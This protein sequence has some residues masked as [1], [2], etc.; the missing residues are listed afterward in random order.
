MFLLNKWDEFWAIILTENLLSLVF[1]YFRVSALCLTQNH[2][3]VTCNIG[4]KSFGPN[5]FHHSDAGVEG[6]NQGYFSNSQLFWINV[7]VVPKDNNE[8]KLDQ[9]LT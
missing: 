5:F 1:I 3:R 4:A 9:K 7:T 2:K 6:V 8:I